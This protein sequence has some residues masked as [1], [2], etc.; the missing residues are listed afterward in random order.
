MCRFPVYRGSI[1]QLLLIVLFLTGLLSSGSEATVLRYLSA[2][3][4]VSEADEVVHGRVISVEEKWTADRKAIFTEVVLEII[5]VFKGRARGSKLSFTFLGGE[6]DGVRLF[7]EHQP[8]FSVDDEVLVF[9]R[10]RIEGKPLLMALSQGVWRV[11]R[12]ANDPRET[13]FVRTVRGIGTTLTSKGTIESF[14]PRTVNS[15]FTASDM[16][17]LV[18]TVSAA[19]VQDES[20]VVE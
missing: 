7:Y 18:A 12:D 17:K 19:S 13:V 3:E 20:G 6:R 16:R 14:D 4:L 11:K 5:E 9:L 1:L 8:S 10:T 15:L 2:E